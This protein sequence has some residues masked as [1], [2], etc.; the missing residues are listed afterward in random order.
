VKFSFHMLQPDEIHELPHEQIK[1]VHTVLVEDGGLVD[2]GYVEENAEPYSV[3]LERLG[4]YSLINTLY[5]TYGSVKQ[6]NSVV[7]MG[8]ETAEYLAVPVVSKLDE[9]LGLEEKGNFVLDAIETNVYA[10]SRLKQEAVLEATKQANQLLDMTEQL[11][12]SILPPAMEFE[13]QE[14][15]DSTESEEDVKGVGERLTENPIPRAAA[16]G[17]DVPKRLKAA[18]L[19]KIRIID[20]KSPTQLES[21]A[22]VVDLIQYA[23]DYVDLEGQKKIIQH[24]GENLKGIVGENINALNTNFVHPVKEIIDKHTADITVPGVRV[25]VGVV[26]SI[27]QAVEV[28]RRQLYRRFGSR[29]KLQEELATITVSTKQAISSMTEH[30][31]VK[32]IQAV[33]ENTNRA[34]S[35]ILELMSTYAPASVTQHLPRLVEW[36]ESINFRLAAATREV[37]GTL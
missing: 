30:D 32:Y 10:A 9:T 15:N 13:F 37:E 34:L 19:T 6:V 12:D 2:G 8:L 4:S 11:V 25:V 17:L 14:L 3:L 29:E 5:R 20:L 24:A 31:L 23:A 22:Y 7:R 1:E 27:A 26:A 36:S 21:V 35:K 33:K 16:L 18:A 28:V